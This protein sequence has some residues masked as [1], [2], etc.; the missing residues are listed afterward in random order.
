MWIAHDTPSW[1]VFYRDSVNDKYSNGRTESRSCRVYRH[2]RTRNR[3]KRKDTRRVRGV[4]FV[5][6][7]PPL[8]K[9]RALR[10]ARYFRVLFSRRPSVAWGWGDVTL[11]TRLSG[12]GGW[13]GKAII[14]GGRARGSSVRRREDDRRGIVGGVGGRWRG[15]RDAASKSV[16]SR[17]V[18]Y[19]IEGKKG[20][21]A[22]VE[23]KNAESPSLGMKFRF[24]PPPRAR[25]SRVPPF[26]IKTFALPPPPPPPLTTTTTT[27][28]IGRC[29]VTVIAAVLV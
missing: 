24:H 29:S 5:W 6:N 11:S 17:H 22:R 8:K 19:G 3:G 10:G 18:M 12:S 1:T 4:V 16:S 9:R 2:R 23:E 15:G 7:S 26:A 25:D 13:G 27:T 21:A 14:G 28:R 20:V